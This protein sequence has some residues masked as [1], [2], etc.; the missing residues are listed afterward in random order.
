[1]K[2]F[3]ACL[4]GLLL[5]ATCVWAYTP[6]TPEQIQAAAAD[7]TLIPGLIEGASDEEAARV[8]RLCI[9]QIDRMDIKI[10]SKRDLVASMLGQ[11]QESIGDRAPLVLGDAFSDVNPELL[12]AVAAA[13]MPI[14]PMGLPTALPLAPPIAPKYTGQ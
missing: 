8:I 2:R 12:P 5:T 3:I 7:P 14:A 1:M 4:L 11:V 9:S 10:E 6:P 13:T